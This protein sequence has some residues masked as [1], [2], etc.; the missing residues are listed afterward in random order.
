MGCFIADQRRDRTWPVLSSAKPV[1]GDAADV[2]FARHG[3][4]A[5]AQRFTSKHTA[6]VAKANDLEDETM[7]IL[8]ALLAVAGGR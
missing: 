3:R 8:S 7:A 1:P 5:D 6:F 2:I 4:N